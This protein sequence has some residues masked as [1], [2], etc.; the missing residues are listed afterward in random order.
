MFEKEIEDAKSLLFE[1]V[2]VDRNKT[3]RRENGKSKRSL[4]DIVCFFKEVDPE[5]I[6][7]ARD[8]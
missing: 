2:K 5:S 6:F 8:L 7:V 4:K 1:S 3:M